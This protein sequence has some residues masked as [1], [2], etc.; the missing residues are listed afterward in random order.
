MV[1]TDSQVATGAT[2]PASC[3]TSA[4]FYN[5]T[6]NVL[7]VCTAT[8]T[9]SI[10]GPQD[11][12]SVYARDEDKILNTSNGNLGLNTGTGNFDVTTTTG[13]ATITSGKA[14]NN[15]I[16]IQASNA[17]GGINANWGTGGLNFSSASGAFS[18][19]GTGNSTVNATSGNLNLQTTTSGNVALTATGA[20]KTI[21]FSDANVT[22]PV[23]FSNTATGL[24]ATFPAGA[25]ILDAINSLASTTAG[26]GASNVGVAAGLTNISGSDVQAALASIDSKIGTS[27]ANVD[28]LTYNPQYPSY[29]VSRDGS[30]NNGTLDMDYDNST[31]INKQYYE[32]TTSNA[33]LSDIDV[34]SSFVLPADFVS[35]GN[36]TLA[37]QTGTATA[38]NNKVD[39]TISNVT[40]L[41]AGA[42]TT[43]GASTANAST[44]W[45]TATISAATL[46]TG[47]TGATALNAGDTVQIDVKFYD[48]SGS[49]TFARASTAS[50]A[51]NN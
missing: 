21:T 20:G 30:N 45:A 27:G 2:D 50:L 41:T 10:A 17:A 23:K 31:G 28:T 33:S 25:G 49:T 7:K 11:L 42:P 4:I 26:E 29:I 40:D 38:A 6:S 51:Y 9:W 15:A 37:Y 14:A 13:K 39:V 44:T 12:E 43:C 47:C 8:D 1:S 22:T 46:N 16:D 5:T 35:T 32:W 19:S 18:I 24:N 34:K 3:S 36:F 48:I